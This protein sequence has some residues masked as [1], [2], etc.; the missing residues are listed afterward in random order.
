MRHRLQLFALVAVVALALA[1]CS[2][3]GDDSSDA[4]GGNTTAAT[5]PTE[6]TATG[7]SATGASGASGTVPEGSSSVMTADSDFGQI[8]V[9]AEGRT[10]YVF[11]PDEGKK[12]TCYDDCEAS[13]PPLLTDG[14]PS[15]DGVDA[16]LLGTTERKDGSTQVTLDGWPLYYFAGD[17]A[18]GDT[19]GQGV[20]EVW[21][22]VAPDGT[23]I[24]DA[25]A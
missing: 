14:S 13:W 25:P 9:D 20:G 22:V 16:S 18:P 8:V 19:N 17:Q 2:N 3:G 7:S 24:T 10:L 12:S 1:A 15:G 5:G 11:D 21:H 23:A 4:A 6:T